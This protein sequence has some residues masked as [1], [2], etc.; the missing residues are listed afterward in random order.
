MKHFGFTMIELLVVIAIIAILAA[1]I[2]PA[3]LNAK[4]SAYRSSDMSHLNELRSALQLYKV[5]QGAY[6]P[7]LFGYVETYA[8]GA[9]AGQTIP[10][11]QIQAFLFPKRVSALSTFTPAYD[12]A[13]PNTV[14]VGGQ[15]DASSDCPAAAGQTP[16]VYWPGEPVSPA[17]TGPSCGYRALGNDVP[18]R[19]DPTNKHSPVVGLYAVDGYDVAPVKE[20]D[21]STKYEVHYALFWTGYGLG[22][23]WNDG[24]SAAETCTYGDSGDDPR[25][26][27]Y[28]NPPDNTVITS[29]TFFRN[30]VN[31]KP[32]AIKRDVVIFLGG[33]A[34]M[35]DS[36]ADASF[37]WTLSP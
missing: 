3:A 6:P 7:E 14:V 33:N 11:D 16:C 26:L 28:S 10:P 36:Q 23:A 9:Q 31:N 13:T 8:T 15:A 37:N 29:D 30:Y 20:L 12:R 34:K 5:D 19:T 25:Q 27:G 4:D 32:E 21:G 18:V 35:Y 1:I 2:F 24:V 17:A 22:P